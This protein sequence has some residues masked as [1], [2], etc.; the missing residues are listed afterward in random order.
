M[1]SSYF[2]WGEA[3]DDEYVTQLRALQEAAPGGHTDTS[4]IAHLWEY[5]R[6]KDIS[7][8]YVNPFPSAS[9]ASAALGYPSVALSK[10]QVSGGKLAA[11]LEEAV[12]W[13]KFAQ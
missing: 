9:P 2:Y 6:I 11:K 7:I 12:W 4:S 3:S 5:F 13:C 10:E 8:D 1:L